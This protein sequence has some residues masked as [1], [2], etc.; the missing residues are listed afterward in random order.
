M[1]DINRITCEDERARAIAEIE[2]LAG[3]DPK[4]A[5]GQEREFLEKLLY[6]YESRGKP[7]HGKGPL[8]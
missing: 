2:R 8:D 3:A 1:V 7:A 5:E 6:E 4:S